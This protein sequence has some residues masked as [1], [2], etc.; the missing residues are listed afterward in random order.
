MGLARDC[1]ED[2]VTEYA[3]RDCFDPECVESIPDAAAFVDAFFG[4]DLFEC[5]T[6]LIGIVC[7]KSLTSFMGL[8]L[9]GFSLKKPLSF[10]PKAGVSTNF[11]FFCV[12]LELYFPALSLLYTL[13]ETKSSSDFIVPPWLDCFTF[14]FF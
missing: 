4:E 13:G 5:D 7:M 6:S 12:R 2:D 1:R 8:Y 14:S 10:V 9:L 11:F 3:F